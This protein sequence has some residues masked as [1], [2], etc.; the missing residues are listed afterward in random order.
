MTIQ[1]KAIEPYLDVLL[2]IILIKTVQTCDPLL[3]TKGL[4]FRNIF[5]LFS[6]NNLSD[7]FLNFRLW[8][9][10]DGVKKVV[11][12]FCIYETSINFTANT[13]VN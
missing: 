8:P 9:F 12:Y 4:L 6:K 1:V 5:P 10:E 2:F 7:L 13:G 11:D 3:I